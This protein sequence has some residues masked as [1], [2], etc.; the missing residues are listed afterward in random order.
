MDASERVPCETRG[1][2]RPA[3]EIRTVYGEGQRKRI[4]RVSFRDATERDYRTGLSRAGK[5]A[6]QVKNG[7]GGVAIG[8]RQHE[9]RGRPL[10][11]C[12][13]QLAGEIWKPGVLTLLC[14]VTG[15]SRVC[16]HSSDV[17]PR[18][19]SRIFRRQSPGVSRK[20]IR[21]NGQVPGSSHHESKGI[22][23]PIA[24]SPPDP[25]A[26]RE[27]VWD[28]TVSQNALEGSPHGLVRGGRLLRPG[29]K[30]IQVMRMLVRG[31]SLTKP[32]SGFPV[33]IEEARHLP[34]PRVG[35]DRTYRRD[36]KQHAAQSDNLARVLRRVQEQLANG[37]DNLSAGVRRCQRQKQESANSFHS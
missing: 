33:L 1:R 31:G 17:Q 15:S 25:V 7:I 22:V 28:E 12:G 19:G 21:F 4:G 20:G 10:R 11:R 2:S 29:P 13:N 26:V 35:D 14:E 24:T 37:V 8:D 3:P 34:A 30:R 16:Q 23:V 6:V 9:P 32:D 36:L 18:S 27:G 5:R